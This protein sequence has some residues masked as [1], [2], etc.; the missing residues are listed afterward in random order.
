MMQDEA[1]V[2]R[3]RWEEWILPE[4]SKRL[5]VI[6]QQQL[7]EPIHDSRIERGGEGIIGREVVVAAKV[8][9]SNHRYVLLYC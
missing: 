5:T 3:G 9:N 8:Q 2:R 1:E 7:R 6:F 4:R